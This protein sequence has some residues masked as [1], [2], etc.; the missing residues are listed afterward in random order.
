MVVHRHKLRETLARVSR[1]LMAGVAAS[2]SAQHKKINGKHYMNGSSVDGKLI[3]TAAR[4]T[5]GAIEAEPVPSSQRFDPVR[6][7]KS[8][9][10]AIAS[11]P[12]PK[13]APRGA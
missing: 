3:E 1:L 12:P 2:K 5:G 9:G 4:E 7:E 13:D 10:E 6:T 8:K 11:Y